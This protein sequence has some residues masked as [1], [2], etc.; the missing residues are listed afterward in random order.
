MRRKCYPESSCQYPIL[1]P[2]DLEIST[3]PPRPP[4]Y[5]R[6]I[7]ELNTSSTGSRFLNGS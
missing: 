1:T 3:L 2:E 7:S 6:K 4:A 5:E